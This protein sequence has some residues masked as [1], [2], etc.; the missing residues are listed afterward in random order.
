[1]DDKEYLRLKRLASR[2]ESLMQDSDFKELLADLKNR[3]IR[4][5]AETKPDDG[6][7]REKAWYDLQAVGRLE[8]LL[9]ALPQGLRLQKVKNDG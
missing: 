3:A 2:A 9:T 7:G 6:A 5:W 8:N 4:D 1:M